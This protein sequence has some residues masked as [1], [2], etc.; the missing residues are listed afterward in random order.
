LHLQAIAMGAGTF[1]KGAC[2]MGLQRLFAPRDKE[3]DIV[4]IVGPSGVGKS[5][6]IKK[7]MEE[8]PGHFGFSVS[9]TTRQPRPGEE[10]GT[11]YLFTTREKMKESIAEGGFIEHAEVHGNFYGTS[12]DAVERVVSSG[13][14]CLLDIDVQGAEQVK[15]SALNTSSAFL[16]VAPP[17][18]A[19]LEERL[20]GR[21]TESEEKVRLRLENA[22]KEMAFEKANPDFFDAVLVSGDLDA[23]Y[24]RFQDFMERQCGRDR[25]RST[26]LTASPGWWRY[27][28]MTPRSLPSPA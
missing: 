28:A 14:I 10:H 3:K 16:F 6:L 22:E 15:R 19:V 11:H 7:L 18:V 21:G 23:A 1:C 5:T 24:A 17:S 20:R 13:K 8:F 2:F 12:Y 4:V 25:L 9:H 26:G 27:A